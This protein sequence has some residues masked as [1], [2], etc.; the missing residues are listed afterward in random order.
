MNIT[1]CGSMQF[2]SRMTE[3]K[4]ELEKRG[5]TVFKPNIVEGHAYGVGED[6]DDN[7][8]LKRGFIDEHLA[9]IDKSEAIMVVNEPKK[10]VDGYIGGNTLIE[11]GYAYSQGLD[12][13]LL[14]QVPEMS[15]ANEIRG[16]HPIVLEGN[17]DSLDGYISKLP[18][19]YMSTTSALKHLALS[20]AMRRAGVSVRV[21]GS[22]VESGVSEQP[23]SIEETYQGVM[24]RHAALKS[25]GKSAN[26]YATVESG[27]HQAHK[28]HS[29]FGCEV[30]MIEIDGGKTKIG[31]DLGLEYPQAMLDKVPSVYPDLGVLVQEEFGADEKDP[32]KFFTEG[33]ILR[34]KLIEEAAYKVAV[35]LLKKE[36]L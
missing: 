10:G 23:Q 2:D 24:N 6:L 16:M 13:F 30:V 8:K 11:I 18:L 33:K 5:H 3:L 32:V 27:L 31:I 25:L 9:K 15:Y 34:Q 21:D 12:I 1:I 14:N 28:D 4:A 7:A 17:L 20:R 22:K 26:Y 36:G 29:L 19:V 35:Q